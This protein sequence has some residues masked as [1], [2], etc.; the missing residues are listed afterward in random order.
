MTRI[1][2]L[3][4]NARILTQSYIEV[5][6]N[7]LSLQRNKKN[8]YRA[9]KK[10]DTLTAERDRDLKNLHS[11][12]IKNSGVNPMYLSRETIISTLSSQ[13]APRFYIK[14]QQAESYVVGYYKQITLVKSANKRA[15]ILDL[16]QVFEK[17]RSEN[18]HL[19]MADIWQLVVMHPAKSFYLSTQRIKEIIFNYRQK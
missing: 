3:T 8:T 12:V 17:I 1:R 9:M 6:K 10:Y 14:A 16:V 11:S 18:M 5:I 13:P 2:N 19:P 7:L 4:Q 15:M